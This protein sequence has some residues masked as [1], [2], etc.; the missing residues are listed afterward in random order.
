VLGVQRNA[1]AGEDRNDKNY[2]VDNGN[3]QYKDH[4]L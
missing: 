3:V 4:V 1:G 2:E